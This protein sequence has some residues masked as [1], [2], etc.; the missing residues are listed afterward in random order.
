MEGALCGPEG[1]IAALGALSHQAGHRGGAHAV[2]WVLLRAVQRL[3]REAGD[4]EGRLPGLLRDVWP[5]LLEAAGVGAAG[6]DGTEGL[7]EE[8]DGV[9]WGEGW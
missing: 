8:L 4:S 6:V 2:G 1:C 7:E 3:S 5:G 9:G